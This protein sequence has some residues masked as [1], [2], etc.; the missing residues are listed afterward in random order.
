M[1]RYKKH[2]IAIDDTLQTIAEQELGDAT[3]WYTLAQAKLNELMGGG[4]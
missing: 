1:A 3:Q 2:V 4:H